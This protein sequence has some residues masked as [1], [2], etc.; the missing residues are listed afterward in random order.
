MKPG[1]ESTKRIA[2]AAALSALPLVAAAQAETYALDPYH[3]IPHFSLEYHGYGAL[4]GR[5]DKM[6]G[7]FTIDRTAKK[8]GLEFAIEAASV[9]TG[10]GE[11]GPR[12]RSRDEHLRTP[13]FFNAVEFPRIT[14]KSTNV[15][16]SGDSPA[17]VEGQLTLLG[18]TKPLTFRI[19][20][21]VCKDHPVY[22]KPSCGGNA[23]A[24]FKRS[25][26]GMK[27]AIPSISDEVRLTTLFLAFRE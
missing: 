23:T 2:L 27:Y 5:F 7:K 6:S 8:G 25:E 24:V 21:W 19:D 13:D 10:D 4:I 20:R 22:K 15:K 3:T 9:N 11:R 18:T 14:F 26:F 16:F 12:P 1:G 17:E